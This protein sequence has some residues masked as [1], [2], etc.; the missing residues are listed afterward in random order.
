MFDEQEIIE[1][2][3]RIINAP[4]LKEQEIKKTLQN[5]MNT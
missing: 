2:F 4:N 3:N 1:F 5:F